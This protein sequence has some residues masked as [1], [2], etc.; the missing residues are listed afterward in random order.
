MNNVSIDV[1]KETAFEPLLKS[2]EAA[3]HLGVHPKTLERMARQGVV[4]SIRYGKRIR[5][6]LSTLD[7]WIRKIENHPSQPLRVK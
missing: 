1:E 7:D 4:P 3:V 6:R 5:F 2:I